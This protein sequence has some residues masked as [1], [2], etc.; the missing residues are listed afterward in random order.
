M[1]R[2][3]VLIAIAVALLAGMAGAAQVVPRTADEYDP[4]LMSNLYVWKGYQFLE[5][6]EYTSA[7]ESSA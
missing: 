2:T 3:L 7:I 4:L 5:D 1:L 6:G